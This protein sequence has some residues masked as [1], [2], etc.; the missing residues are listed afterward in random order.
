[1]R[2][3][4]S[5][6]ASPFAGLPRRG[7]LLL[8]LWGAL[9]L[10]APF[11]IDA[12]LL[13]VLTLVLWLA[14]TGQ[15]WNVMMGFAGQLSLG[16]TLYVGLAAY[17]SGVLFVYFG[18]GPWLGVWLAI[19]I[20]ALAGAGIG[21]LG[22]RFG[23]KGVY[24]ALLTIAFAEF[25]RIAFDH[26]GWVGGSAGFFLPVAQRTSNDLLDLRGTPVMFYYVILA[27]TASALL[28]CRALLKSRLGYYWLAIREDQEAAQAV[29][30]D[31]FR[32]KLIA[33]VISA[34][35]TAPAGV[36]YAFF[37]NNMYPEQIFAISRSIEIILGAIVGG[38]GTLFGPILGAFI[39]T[40]L[41]ELVTAGIERAGI[42]VPGAKQLVYGGLMVL[43]VV[44][45]PDGIWPWLARRLRLDGRDGEPRA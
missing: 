14:Y 44:F 4:P 12:Y 37:Y 34:A 21:A 36:F 33:V 27:L 18:I 41:G 24:F 43:I 23:I 30:I 22:F 10:A 38:I 8:A 25:T 42:D 13:S 35:L 3:E 40:P 29:G 16:H 39:L 6:S 19:V 11:L 7:A 2:P 45:L 1:M 9:M 5:T 20:A 28:L 17:A 26:F 15:A 31:V 32:Y